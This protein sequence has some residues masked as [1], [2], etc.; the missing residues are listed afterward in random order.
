M[1]NKCQYHLNHNVNSNNNRKF[2]GFQLTDPGVPRAKRTLAILSS[3]LTINKTLEELKDDYLEP[4]VED[5]SEWCRKVAQFVLEKRKRSWR[6]FKQEWLADAFPLCEIGI[7]FFARCFK[8]HICVFVNSHYW[9]THRADD[10]QQ[11]SIFLA[12]HGGLVFE[13]TQPMTEEQYRASAEAIGRVQAKFDEAK[14]ATVDKGKEWQARKR[15]IISSDEEELDLE[16]LLEDAKDKNNMQK[17]APKMKKCTVA[18]KRLDDIV[19]TGTSTPVKKPTRPA[20]EDVTNKEHEAEVKPAKNKMWNDVKQVNAFRLQLLDKMRKRISVSVKISRQSV[21]KAKQERK[22]SWHQVRKAFFKAKKPKR[23]LCPADNCNVSKSSKAAVRRHI[24][25]QHKNFRWKCRKCAKTFA[26]RTGRYKHELK[27][28]YGFRFAC[29]EA[30]CGYRCM[31]ESEM[32]EHCKKHSRKKLWKCRVDPD[33]NKQYPA[34]RTR[35][36]HEK[37]HTAEDWT[38]EA[39]TE[40]NEIC[41]QECVSR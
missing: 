23:F 13:D 35:N 30:G 14:L 24:E 16:N 9:T 19:S 12:Y 21:S 22:D 7:T 29:N 26:Q 25:E 40:D 8:R 17:P 38:C 34:K 41:G 6:S 2:F 20:N 39:T 33:C 3:K 31:F 28:K 18:L 32:I 15:A 37:T 36:A 10:L 5:H 27:H 1:W 11:C 4:F